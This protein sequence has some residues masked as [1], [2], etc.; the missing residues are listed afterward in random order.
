MF[1]NWSWETGKVDDTARGDDSKSKIV[2]PVGNDGL[3]SGSFLLCLVFGLGLNAANKL[4]LLPDSA[5][6]QISSELC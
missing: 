4:L 5:F 6:G 1:C 3:S 2:R